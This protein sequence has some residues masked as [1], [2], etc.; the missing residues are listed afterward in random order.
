MNSMYLEN[1]LNEVLSTSTY[2]TKSNSMVSPEFSQ[3]IHRLYLGKQQ[4]IEQGLC[5][6]DIDRLYR[7]LFVHS[8]GFIQLIKETGALLKDHQDKDKRGKADFI[9]A[10]VWRL[11]HILLEFAC[12]S[13]YELLIKTEEEKYMSRIKQLEEHIVLLESG[14]SAKDVALREKLKA[15]ND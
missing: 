7:A 6:Q 10:N 1:W 8:M 12:R 15:Q 5:V 4:L 2:I 3:P 14:Q 9:K 13:D 11:F